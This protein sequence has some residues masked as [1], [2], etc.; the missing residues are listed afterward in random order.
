[1]KK[2]LVLGLLLTGMSVY[3]AEGGD[4]SSGLVA[5]KCTK[6]K[7]YKGP[8][9]GTRGCQC[10][11][12]ASQAPAVSASRPTPPPVAPEPGGRFKVPTEDVDA[13]QLKR[14]G[15]IGSLLTTRLPF[16]TPV[17]E[18][19]MPRVRTGGAAQA[20]WSPDGGRT[21]AEQRI[22]EEEDRKFAEGLAGVPVRDGGLDLAT[23]ELIE[24]IMLED[25]PDQIAGGYD[26]DAATQQA[27]ADMLAADLA[28]QEAQQAL[29]DEMTARQV[30]AEQGAQAY[31][32]R[33]EE[34]KRDAKFAVKL[35]QQQQFLDAIGNLKAAFDM[36]DLS[37]AD[38]A[39][40]EDQIA[41]LEAQ[42]FSLGL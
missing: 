1:M 36:T 27:I 25:F 13:A 21:L 38:R 26:P 10:G 24:Q 32:D 19:V 14:T 29:V 6:C 28:A 37:P 39:S 5:S 40:I 4:R 15:E 35:A 11:K 8:E 3:A 33:Q 18:R 41:E 12:P 23:Q 22:Q 34:I 9:F 30:A 7:K 42:L 31:K 20:L 17:A 16:D 2:L